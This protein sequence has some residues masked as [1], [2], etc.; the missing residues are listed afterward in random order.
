MWS[1]LDSADPSTR[2]PAQP[3]L[4]EFSKEEETY[5]CTECR[6]SRPHALAIR[7]HYLVTH[8][9]HD[10]WTVLSTTTSRGFSRVYC[11]FNDC[12][13][14]VPLED[15]VDHVAD[16]HDHHPSD[17][18]VRRLRKVKLQLLYGMPFNDP[19]RLDYRHVYLQQSSPLADSQNICVMNVPRAEWEKD[20]PL[21]RDALAGAT[22]RV[23]KRCLLESTEPPSEKKQRLTEQ[24]D[25][26][27]SQ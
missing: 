16:Q 20:R 15:F 21:I 26:P 9:H 10:P 8:K 23:I 27:C 4:P 18:N 24:D 13:E 19:P 25:A 14:K 12:S 7:S 1:Y 22:T 6:F 5:K 3:L 17:S 11:P 2:L